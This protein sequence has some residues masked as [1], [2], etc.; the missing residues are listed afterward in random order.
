MLFLTLGHSLFPGVLHAACGTGT[1]RPCACLPVTASPSPELLRSLAGV[2]HRNVNVFLQ[3][4]QGHGQT[5]C[6]L[7][8]P[9]L[10]TAGAC[11]ILCFFSVAVELKI[12]M[13]WDLTP[14]KNASVFP[15]GPLV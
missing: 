1:C 2:Q 4:I 15:A 8:P 10:L 7:L 9:S 6:C 13:C 12:K 11:F 3:L 5:R 14:N